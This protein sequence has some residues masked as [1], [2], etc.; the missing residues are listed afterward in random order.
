MNETLEKV[1]HDLD[2]AADNLCT[3]L[4][5]GTAVEAIILLTLL[6]QVRKAQ[7]DT[8]ALMEARHGEK[9]EW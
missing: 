9:S 6:A 1:N 2:R 4:H 5:Q 3:A 7:C 8:K